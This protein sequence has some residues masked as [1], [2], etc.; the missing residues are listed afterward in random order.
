MSDRIDLSEKLATF[1]EHWSPRAVAE[2]NNC[3]VMVVKVK[4]EFVWHK[5]DDTE[6]LPFDPHRAMI[7]RMADLERSGIE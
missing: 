2:F 7:V 4:G 5:H 3:D 6:D 1:S